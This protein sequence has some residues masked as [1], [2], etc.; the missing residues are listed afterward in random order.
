[1]VFCG[2]CSTFGLS[3]LEEKHICVS[4]LRFKKAKNTVFFSLFSME[5]LDSLR[6]S[7][8]ERLQR[9]LTTC[10]VNTKIV[11]CYG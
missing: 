1:M 3:C 9:N 4:Y 5:S 6:D 2:F 11:T 10:L 8:G 7:K